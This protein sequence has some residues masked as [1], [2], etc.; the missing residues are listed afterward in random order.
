MENITAAVEGILFAAGEPVAQ[1]R[2]AHILEVD[3]KAIEYALH[4]L[5]AQYNEKERG[6]RLVR[7]ED[8]AQLCS[9]PEYA[10]L[11]RRVLEKRR[12]PQLSP[13]AL[14][15]LAIVAYFQPVTRAYVERVRGVDSSYTM[16]TLQARGLIEQCGQLQVPGRPALF[17]TSKG[18][19]RTF[20]LQA[21]DDLPPLPEVEDDEA[22]TQLKETIAAIQKEQEAAKE[23]EQAAQVAVQELRESLFADE[24]VEKPV[25]TPA[26][27]EEGE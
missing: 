8:S 11:I 24:N 9:A 22:R 12:V 26:E 17:Q 5:E 1:K 3:D 13:T 20:G 27:Q 14:E 25:E 7:M 4:K 10:E 15:A 23:A 16:S 6:I 18:F 21:L 19:L 2:L